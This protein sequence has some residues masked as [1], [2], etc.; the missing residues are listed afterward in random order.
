M[1]SFTFSITSIP[2]RSAAR[3]VYVHFL[4]TAQRTQGLDVAMAAPA[5][6]P[7][8]YEH[9]H[10]P[11]WGFP[12]SKTLNLTEL[13]G[14]GDPS[15]FVA[16]RRVLA[17]TNRFV[18]YIHV[19]RSL[20]Q[21]LM[22]HSTIAPAPGRST[23]MNIVILDPKTAEYESLLHKAVAVRAVQIMMH[24]C[25]RNFLIL[26]GSINTVTPERL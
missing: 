7:S 23:L 26:A 1:R 13:Y 10:L 25:A 14:D 6:S 5:P 22:P 24:T 8:R 21:L 4:A 11:V 2:T 16:F 9:D 12:V 18:Q 3:E 20:H 17:M 19:S 15:A